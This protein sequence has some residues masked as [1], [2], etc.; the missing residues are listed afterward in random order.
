VLAAYA[1]SMSYPPTTDK[2]FLGTL[3]AWF[4]TQPEILVLIRVRCG[5]GSKDFELF[6]SFE[7]LLSRIYELRAGTCVTVFKQ[8]QLPIRGVVDE[9]FIDKCLSNIPEGAEY[10]MVE[11][12]KT[13]AGKA[14]WFHYGSDVTLAGLR[15]DLQESRGRPVAVGIYPPVLEQNDDIIDAVVPDADGIVRAG[16]Y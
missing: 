12:V 2:T 4:R 1:A 15:D 5:A 14:S 7:A 16:P 9:A 10:L 13:F 11:T 6:C 8:P 3:E